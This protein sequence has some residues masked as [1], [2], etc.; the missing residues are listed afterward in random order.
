MFLSLEFTKLIY[1]LEEQIF[2]L[3]ERLMA[4]DG[5]KTFTAVHVCCLTLKRSIPPAIHLAFL[6]Y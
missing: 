3:E 6:A 4:H 1:P 5:G 2:G